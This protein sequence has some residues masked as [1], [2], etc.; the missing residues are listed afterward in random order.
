MTPPSRQT[1]TDRRT[2]TAPQKLGVVRAALT[3]RK[4]MRLRS[5]LL[6]ALGAAALSMSVLACSIGNTGPKRSGAVARADT[7]RATSTDALDVPSAER[8][9]VDYFSAVA[10]KDCAHLQWLLKPAPKDAECQYTFEQFEHHR[11]RLLSIERWKRDGRARGVLLATVRMLND[12]REG[13]Y[14]FRLEHGD[15]NWRVRA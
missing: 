12:G 5:W 3:E 8:T 15:G 11:A 14:V 13:E 6:V 7:P 2:R 9:L 10:R 1:A 4:L